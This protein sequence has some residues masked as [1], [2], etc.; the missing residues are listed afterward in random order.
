VATPNLKITA[1]E[2]EPIAAQFPLSEIGKAEL[3]PAMPPINFL[4]ALIAKGAYPDAIQF[5]ARA[6]PKREA[7]W[8]TCLCCR[9]ILGKDGEPKLATAVQAAEAWVYKPNEENRRGAEKAGNAI[10]ESHPARWVAMAAFWSGGSLAPPSA[11]EVKPP[12]DFTAKAVTGA[13]LMAASLDP[14]QADARNKQFTDYGM[15]IAKGGNG[16]AAP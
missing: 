6:L 15:N 13:V 7:V 12:D 8:W 10:S 4:E 11:P 2:A 1:S 5:L 14:A 3:K 16:R 9:D